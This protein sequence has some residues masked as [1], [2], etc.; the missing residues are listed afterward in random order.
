[1][2]RVGIPTDLA[3][4]ALAIKNAGDRI[5]RS[6]DIAITPAV[7]ERRLSELAALKR[8]VMTYRRRLRCEV[9]NFKTAAKAE[10]RRRAEEDAETRARLKR[11]GGPAVVEAPEGTE[12]DEARAA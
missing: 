8:D 1:M 4:L 5:H 11:F 9:A 6:S 3:D 10:D 2:N 12:F 7:A